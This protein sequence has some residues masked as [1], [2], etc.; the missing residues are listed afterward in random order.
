MGTSINFPDNPT[1]GDTYT[2]GDVTYKFDGTRWYVLTGSITSEV[3]FENL[4]ANGDVGTGA[5]QV[6]VGNDSRFSDTRTPTDDSVTAAKLASSI[7]GT[8]A[9]LVCQGNDSR[10]SNT[11]IPTDDSVTLDKLEDELKEVVTL[12]ASEVDWMAAI[13]F[14]KTLIATTTITDANL[15]KGK[16]VVL[17]IT[18]DFSITF[19]AY[20]DIMKGSETYDGTITNTITVHCIESASG[21]EEVEYYI[22]QKEV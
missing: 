22:N 3:T 11:R 8:A 7:F 12:S 10:L 9:G 21:S 17:H 1:I 5:A 6:A 2:Y 20:W 15:V 18:G 19:P 4:N 16:V 13:E 14:A